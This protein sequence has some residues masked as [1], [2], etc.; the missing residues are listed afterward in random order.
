MRPLHQPFSA[1]TWNQKVCIK[2]SWVTTQV[3]GHRNKQAFIMPPLLLETADST[4][5]VFE[6]ILAEYVIKSQLWD[7]LSGWPWASYL[8]SL[9]LMVLICKIGITVSS[10]KHCLGGLSIMCKQLGTITGTW[11]TASVSSYYCC[12]YNNIN[13]K[14]KGHHMIWQKLWSLSQNMERAKDNL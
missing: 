4:H 3:S 9:S 11:Y 13:I 14:Q 1:D 10:T 12:Y 5:R 6:D 7:I 8:T 2:L